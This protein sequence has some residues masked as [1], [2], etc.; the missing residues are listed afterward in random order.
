MNS[1]WKPAI[2]SSSLMC[3]RCDSH[4]SF[5][6]PPTPICTCHLLLCPLTS[7]AAGCPPTFPVECDQLERQPG[8][9]MKPLCRVCDRQQT[10]R[11]LHT[12][13]LI[14]RPH[15]GGGQGN[16][17]RCAIS[18]Q[19]TASHPALLLILSWPHAWPKTIITIFTVLPFSAPVPASH[20]LRPELVSLCRCSDR[21]KEK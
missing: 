5:I 13:C 20:V 15:G 8:L 19:C 16:S 1:S 4:A 18:A 7:E 3:A 21:Q 11:A 12:A 2:I 9:R 17:M 14:I 10:Q 6:Q